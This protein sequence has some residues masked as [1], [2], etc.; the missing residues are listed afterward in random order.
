MIFTYRSFS[1]LFL[2]SLLVVI[3]LIFGCDKKATTKPNKSKI[4]KETTT[5]QH[6]SS[7][8]PSFSFIVIGDSRP[9]DAT[10]PQPTGFLKLIDQ[11]KNEKVDFVLH[12]G[13]AV[14][15]QTKKLT[16]YMKQYEEFL[17]IMSRLPFP[18]HLAPGNH[19]L[20]GKT[21]EKAFKNTL[22]QELYYSFNHKNSHFIILNTELRRQEGKITRKQL[23]WLK[24]DLSETRN[25]QH[26]FIVMHRPLYSV[27]NPE[28]K[29]NKHAAFTNKRNEYEIRSLMV[30]YQVNAV[31]AGHEHLFNK[32]IHDGV[33]YI[34]TGP[35]GASPYTDEAHGGFY[36]YVKV[37]VKGNSV[38]IKV[39]KLG[40]EMINPNSVSKPLFR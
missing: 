13:D 14:A 8:E 3:V 27:L 2:I 29:K 9:A 15:G 7:Q 40:G 19:D 30:Q 21:G 24:E 25:N 5:K 1:K 18:F 39:I 11:I 34:I 32:Q 4:S 37:N 35:A 20:M 28:G 17:R 36:H 23:E 38:Y 16:L 10:S 26:I 6:K 12:A 22:K 33:T 31:F